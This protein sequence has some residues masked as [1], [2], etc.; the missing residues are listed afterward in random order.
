MIQ[1]PDA[2]IIG[3]GIS[4]AMIAKHL[5]LSGK[6]VVIL[7]AGQAQPPDVNAYMDRFLTATAKVP[8]IPYPPDL[9]DAKGNLTDPATVNAGRPTVLTLNA[10]GPTGK[11]FGAWQDPK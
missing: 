10:N 8:E 9:F 6:K 5:A 3:S 11:D 1:T 4:G 7:E 2:V